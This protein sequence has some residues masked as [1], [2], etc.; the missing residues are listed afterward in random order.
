MSFLSHVLRR[1]A[2]LDWPMRPG[3]ALAVC[4]SCGADVVVPV[5]RADE[6]PWHRWIR[7]R[8]R[9]GNC[10]RFRETV[11]ADRD[12]Q[13]LDRRI[14]RGAGEIACALARIDRQRMERQADLLAAA[15]QRDLI[16][17]TDFD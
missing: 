3:D 12:V 15:F 1:L 17:A 2:S 7:L 10:G 9:C 4:R 13:A 5:H 16:D 8:L 11:A 14:E 6:D